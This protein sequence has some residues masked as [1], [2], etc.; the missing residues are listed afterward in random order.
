M[1]AATR[2]IRSI[3]LNKLRHTLIALA[4]AALFPSDRSTCM[5]QTQAAD[6]KTCHTAQATELAGSIHET[7][8]C[9]E[10]HGGPEKFQLDGAVLRSF[11]NRSLDSGMAFDHGSTF[12]GKPSRSEVPQ[13][14]GECHAD[15][16]RMNPYGLRTDQLARYWT[17]G[18]GQVLKEQ[19]DETVAVCTDCHGTHGILDQHQ[20]QSKTY[21]LNI[22]D[23]CGT[24]H[25]DAAIM[26]PFDHPVQ[27]VD[28]YKKSVHG[29]LLL[30]QGD[31]GAPTCSTCHGNHSAMPPGFT[32]VVSVCGKCHQ[33][34]AKNF[35][36]SIHAQQE[37]HHG[38]VQC[39]G[40]GENR[41]FHQIERITKP[42]GVMIQRY[43][44]LLA[45]ESDPTAE[46]IA[47]AIHSEPKHIITQALPS[48]MECH[49]DLEDDESLPKLFN[50]IDEIAS[51]ESYY[52]RTAQRIDEVGRGVLLVDNERFKF[53][54]AKTHLI[55]LAPVQHSLN[56]SLV[57]AEVNKLTAVCDDVNAELDN[58]EDG[59][60]WRFRALIPIWAFA[61]VF[62]V[63]IYAKYRRLE[64]AYVKPLPKN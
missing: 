33:H 34:A 11:T 30:E 3:S 26:A 61:I 25:A 43:A 40:G 47:A 62:A 52:V 1:E 35:A 36:T 21:P 55:G 45:T 24:C 48:C 19:G 53:E 18:H 15:V 27:I 49:E 2:N 13:R 37:E 14:C 4:V 23:T 58:Q 6:C 17:S 7:L 63:L 16:R 57:E 60:E 44:H 5:A 9:Q 31:T 50:L 22:P 29:Q 20:P 59:L 51:A 10:C 8:G 54:E 12:K 32:T 41:Y 42:A 56:N 64:H 39:H 46:Q 38:C 28:E